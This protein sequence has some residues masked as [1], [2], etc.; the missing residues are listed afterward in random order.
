MGRFKSSYPEHQTYEDRVCLL[1][2][3]VVTATGAGTIE[4]EIPCDSHAVLA[5][6]TCHSACDLADK[7]DVWVQTE[8][9]GGDDLYGTPT[10]YWTDVVHFVQVNGNDGAQIR[11]DKIVADWDQADF[12]AIQKGL[13]SGLKR[14]LFGRKYRVVWTVTNG[15][16]LHSFL[17]GVGLQPM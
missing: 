5:V 7:L 11:I 6:L 16:G 14:H 4:A 9:Y 8:L 3:Q 2:Q 12:V 1:Q 10:Y 15:G 17:F 13:G